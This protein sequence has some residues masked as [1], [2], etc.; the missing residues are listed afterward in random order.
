MLKLLGP[1]HT[2]FHGLW[3]W[4][5]LN[6]NRSSK[7]TLGSF[8]LC[9]FEKKKDRLNFKPYL[10]GISGS[11][12]QATTK[13]YLGE[14]VLKRTRNFVIEYEFSDRNRTL[15]HGYQFSR[16]IYDF[17]RGTTFLAFIPHCDKYLGS[18]FRGDP[19]FLGWSVY[20]SIKTHQ[21]MLITYKFIL[22]M[23]H[24][25]PMNTKQIFDILWCLQLLWIC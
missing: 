11:R 4:P 7:V 20:R 6:W 1:A 24:P 23:L 22:C 14:T 8:W 17:S 2:L 5:W 18:M 13:L 25:R 9:A 10:K 19:D 15:L 3:P 12:T 21:D 16:Y